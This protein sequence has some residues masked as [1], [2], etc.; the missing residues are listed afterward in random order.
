MTEMWQMWQDIP[1][2][3][4]ILFFIFFL[5]GIANAVYTFQECGARALLLGDKAAVAA[6]LGMCD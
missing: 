6:W 4:R 2:W 1:V 3:F 5:L